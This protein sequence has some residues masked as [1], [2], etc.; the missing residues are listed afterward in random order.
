MEV[1]CD[2]VPRCVAAAL[3]VS[4][5]RKEIKDIHFVAKAHRPVSV[6]VMWSG[7]GPNSGVYPFSSAGVSPP[8]EFTVRDVSALGHGWC[9][10]SHGAHTSLRL[11]PLQGVTG[12]RSF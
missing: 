12:S 10:E 9:L 2:S 3:P 5:D 11:Q 1:S 8:S 7:P 6:N 4:D